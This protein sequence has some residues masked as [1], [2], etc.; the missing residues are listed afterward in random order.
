MPCKS[1]GREMIPHYLWRQLPASAK[2]ALLPTHARQCG[3]GI[4]TRCTARHRKAGTLIDFEL[5]RLTHRDIMDEYDMLSRTQGFT[6][7]QIADRLGIHIDT[8]KRHLA[9]GDS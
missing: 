4:C 6:D 5:T 9:K 7:A 1:C 2:K 3:R 8:L